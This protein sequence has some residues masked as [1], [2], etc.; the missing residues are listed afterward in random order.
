LLFKGGL[1]VVHLP[2]PRPLGPMELAAAAEGVAAWFCLAAVLLTVATA[3]QEFFVQYVKACGNPAEVTSLRHLFWLRALFGRTRARC[4]GAVAEMPVP[5][6]LRAPLYRLFARVCGCCLEEVRGALESFPSLADFFCRSLREGARP[7]A[8]LPRG[9]V[10]P[11]DGRLLTTGVVDRPDTR[12]EQVKGTTYSVRGLLGL[13]PTK[14]K[15]PANPSSS[16][17]Y[18]VIYLRPGDYHQVHSPCE[19][20][21]QYGR[22]F[23]GELLPVGGGILKWMHDVFCVNER[24]VLSGTWLFGA[25][26]L[27]LVAA[28]NVGNIYLNFDDSLQTNNKRDLTVHCGGDVASRLYDGGVSLAAG[29]ALGGFR[30][31]S[32]VVLVFD[33]PADFEW[34]VPLGGAVRVGE[35]LG[36]VP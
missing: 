1:F 10:S 14:T 23:P 24:V 27:I 11:V 21:V 26:H 29:D 2:Q 18:A 34:L 28:A 9:L 6:P 17:H 13:D 19:C 36:R 8:S 33:G 4:F 7:V 5:R 32:T 25:M 3:I 30:L 12:V 16:V 20:A 22:H 35:A 15:D 31:G